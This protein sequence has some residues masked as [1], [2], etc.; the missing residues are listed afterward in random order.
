MKKEELV[1][2]SKN[3]N[4]WNSFENAIC[5][6]KIAPAQIPQI[7]VD[8]SKDDD[9]VDDIDDDEYDDDDE[10]DEIDDGN[11]DGS[12]TI[13]KDTLIAE[14]LDV[15]KGLNERLMD[16]KSSILCSFSLTI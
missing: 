8:A 11:D 6:K 9:I 7:D 3:Y 14:E 13:T 4:S 12:E 2:T 5:A 10:D 15:I 16:R 1:E